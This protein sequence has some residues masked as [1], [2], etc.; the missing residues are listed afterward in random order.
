MKKFIINGRFL[1]KRITGAPRYAKEIIEGLDSICSPGEFEL[2]IP[3][4]VEKAPE[5]KNI[6]VVR[7]GKLHNILWEHFS[8]PKY[9][10]K[11]KAIALNL[12]NVAPIRF[13]GVVCIHDMRV[14]TMPKTVTL[15]FRLWYRF[16]FHFIVKR[17]KMLL[18]VSE[19]SKSEILKYYKKTNPDKIKVIPNAW[20]HYNRVGF[21][22]NALD[23]Y[24]LTSGGYCFSM[25]SMDPNKNFKWVAEIAKNNPDVAFAV[26]GAVDGKIFADGLGFECPPN[27][28]LLG[29]VSDEE[30]KALMKHCK[31]F[32]F[33]SFYEGFGIPPLEAMAAGCKKII[34][35]DIPVLKEI[36]EDSLVYIDPNRY[37]YDLNALLEAPVDEGAFARILNKYSW[38]KS[39]KMLYDLTSKI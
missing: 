35:S 14:R 18:T 6:K 8:F 7:I 15:G 27:M 2:A 25:G 1:G 30:A 32:I 3:P 11:Q 39:S 22:E 19:Y 4:E 29:Y 10:K 23:K 5:Y 13:P 17:S 21:D 12:V 26:S 33:P 28:K 36:F 31:A 24:G 38:E 16:L 9:V 37:D 20:Q 34:A